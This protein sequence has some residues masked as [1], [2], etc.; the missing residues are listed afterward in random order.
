MSRLLLVFKGNRFNLVIRNC[1]WEPRLIG[2]ALFVH[3]HE[4][5]HGFRKEKNNEPGVLLLKT[6]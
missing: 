2:R 3:V 4:A 1:S 6:V 5:K